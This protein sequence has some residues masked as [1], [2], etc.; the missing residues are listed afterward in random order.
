[1]AIF[2]KGVP[3]M[4]AEKVTYDNTTSEF[5]ADDVQG[6]IDEIDTSVD[7]L[8][9][10]KAIVKGYTLSSAGWDSNDVYTINDSL[11]TT[12]INASTQIIGYPSEQYSDE[13]YEVLAAANI[14]VVSV[15]TGEIRLKAMDGAPSINL[16][17]TITYRAGAD[18]VTLTLDSVPT[19][20][21][22]NP[23]TSDGVYNSSF[24]A[25]GESY[26]LGGEFSLSGYLSNSNKTISFAIPLPKKS[27][28]NVTVNSL[29][30]NIR[31]GTGGYA[32]AQSGAYVSGGFNYLPY[33]NGN[34]SSPFGS[35][36]VSL[37]ITFSDN[38]NATNNQTVSVS[39]HNITITFN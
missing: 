22:N 21:S 15:A 23:I 38:Q 24:F 16:P 37:S 30:A 11:I 9:A 25:A 20:G 34:I 2:T 8:N 17:I 7:S 39:A 33:Y 26:T 27:T 31:M 1:M 36:Y 5:V 32:V 12:G 3:E 10:M 29:A 35:Y 14:R 19:S 28:G 6:A 13:M 4:K 18:P